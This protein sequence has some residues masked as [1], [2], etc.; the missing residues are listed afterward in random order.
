VRRL[1]LLAF[2]AIVAC[3]GP[4]TGGPSRSEPGSPVPGFELFV[5]TCESSVS[6]DLGAGW[7]RGE[8]AAGP[9]VFVAASGYANDPRRLFSAPGDRATIHKVLVVVEGGGAVE[10]SVDH[11]D[12]ALAYDPAKWGQRNRMRLEAGDPRVR[13][14]PCPGPRSTQ[15]NGGFLVRGPTCV[16]VEVQGQEGTP[17]FATLS[18]GSGD[19]S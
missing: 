17:A 4:G 18:F 7:R 16:P 2:L 10:V 1:A 12:A 8:A 13:F 6:G 15:F 9:I 5:R 14:E 3:T 19:C 11:P